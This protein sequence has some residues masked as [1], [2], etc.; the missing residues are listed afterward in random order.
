MNRTS[1]YVFS[2]YVLECHATNLMCWAR[3]YKPNHSENPEW[4]NEQ[5]VSLH[6]AIE[7][8]QSGCNKKSQSHNSVLI[9]AESP[10]I[11]SLVPS[12]GLRIPCDCSPDYL[13]WIL[14]HWCS[15][16]AA[17]A[18]VIPFKGL[19]WC[20]TDLSTT[21]QFLITNMNISGVIFKYQFHTP[22]TL[23]DFSSSLLFTLT[24]GISHITSPSC[25]SQFLS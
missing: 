2:G 17:K 12:G 4:V 6:I 21:W 5:D 14:Y 15:S 8:W 13:L 11:P 10:W 25:S 1:F 19:F 16:W 18:L 23:V 24:T 7:Q 20:R 22:E 9:W 3:V